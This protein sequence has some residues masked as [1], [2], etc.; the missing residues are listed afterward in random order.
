M[1]EVIFFKLEEINSSNVPL[2]GSV[3]LPSTTPKDCHTQVDH[4]HSIFSMNDSLMERSQGVFPAGKPASCPHSCLVGLAHAKPAS[5]PILSIYCNPFLHPI[6]PPV[7]ASA[8]GSGATAGG[9]SQFP[10]LRCLVLLKRKK[11]I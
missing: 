10:R 7:V 9:Q 2:L 5:A 11:N 6:S 1:S 8:L 4:F 3:V